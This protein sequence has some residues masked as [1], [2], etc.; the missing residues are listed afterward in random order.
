[1]GMTHIVPAAANN[2]LGSL[3]EFPRV[4]LFCAMFDKQVLTAFIAALE[5]AASWGACSNG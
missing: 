3:P 4:S 5:L 1:M 2:R